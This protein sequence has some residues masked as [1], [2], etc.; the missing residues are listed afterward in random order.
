MPEELPT[1]IPI[2]VGGY[3]FVTR[4]STLKKYTDSMLAAMF[5]GRHK[6]DR[7]KHGYYFIDSN[8]TYF[9]YILDFLRHETMPPGDA[10]IN[11]YKEAC[12]Y[13]ISPLVEKL[14]TTPAVAK[15]IVRDA[16]RAQFPDYY[17]IKQKVIRQAM[18]NAVVDQTGEVILYAFKKVFTPRAPYFNPSH[19]CVADSAHIQIGP[20]DST[21]EEEVLVRCLEQD[22]L[23][24]GFHIK[25]HE[26][27]RRCKYYNGQNCQKSV[28]KIT[29]I[30]H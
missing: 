23:A 20:W 19:D 3:R 21:V 26:A 6:L 2:N 4:I 25:S 12:Y 29:F 11:V 18:D 10:A 1:V 14:Q 15:M 28:Y 30:F 7:D 13:N 17:G 5:S 22:L 9:G 8:G 24:D 16:H 27:R